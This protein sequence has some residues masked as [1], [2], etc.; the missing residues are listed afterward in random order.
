MPVLRT[1]L[2]APDAISPMGQPSLRPVLV[3][4][5]LGHQ[6]DFWTALEVIDL[7]SSI[8]PIGS[9][10]T[11]QFRVQMSTLDPQCTLTLLTADL[12]V[13][14][15]HRFIPTGLVYHLVAEIVS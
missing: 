2:T 14:V 3:G 6:G 9:T 15:L 5:L 13:S 7:P 1:S 11:T 4:E 8:P 12:I 10:I